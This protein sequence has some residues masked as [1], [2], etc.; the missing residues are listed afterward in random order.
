ME[1]GKIIEVPLKEIW[2]GEATHFTPW[3]AAN[4][5]ILSEK[6]GLELELEAIEASAGDFA[7]DIIAKDIST[8]RRVIIENQY[9][10]TDHRH[11]GQILTY[12][13]VLNANVVIWIAERIRSEHKS[14]ID[15]LNQ[16]LKETLQVYAIE[17]SVIRIEDSKPAFNLKAVC[18]PSEASTISPSSVSEATETQDKYRSYYQALLDE[19]R[20]THK[21]TNAKAAQPQNWYTFSSENSKVFKYS[22]AF[23]H[24]SRV[25]VELYI[26]TGEKL[27]N[28][29]I[30]DQ[31]Y[32]HSEEIAE[33]YGAELTW[34][35][36]DSKRACRIAVYRDG[37]I[38]VESEALLEIRSWMINNLLKMRQ[39]LPAFVESAITAI[40]SAA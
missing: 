40:D 36:L 26:D 12:S 32:L 28:E 34:E 38:D 8:N 4:L 10:S 13:S 19:L 29:A 35:R 22:T 2:S 14:A 11:L 3:L 1:F 21:F 31:L 27:R 25:R 6:L 18:S 17:A 30:F 33:A 15:F 39:I 20:V 37:D 24:G 9:G 23:T 16:N 5:N 7:A